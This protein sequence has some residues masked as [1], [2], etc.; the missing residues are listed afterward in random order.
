MPDDDTA[1]RGDKDEKD[2]ETER[3]RDRDRDDDRDGGG[4][5]GGRDRDRDDD[6]DDM[7]PEQL[8]AALRE[9][10]REAASYRRKLRDTE[11]ERDELR[12]KTQTEQERAIADAVKA[13][14]EELTAEHRKTLIGLHVKAHAAAKFEDPADAL[15]FVDVSEFDDLDEDKLDRAIERALDEVLESKP[16]LAKDGDGGGERDRGRKRVP[17][18]G[19]RGEGGGRREGE[20]DDWLRRR[21]RARS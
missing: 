5:R 11:R 6:R 3:D 2:R 17:S 1:G 14:E 9:T 19:P 18:P 7:P 13:R 16:Y 15:R 12:G 8:K 20:T 21:A 4:D 10:R